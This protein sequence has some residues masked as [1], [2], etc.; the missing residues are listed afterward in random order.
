MNITSRIIAK[1]SIKTGE[2]PG[3]NTGQPNPHYW[4][5]SHNAF[6][7][8]NRSSKKRLPVLF[9]PAR[10]TINPLTPYSGFLFVGKSSGNFYEQTNQKVGKLTSFDV[11][12]QIKADTAKRKISA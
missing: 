8:A 7:S 3:L 10:D 9:S 4:N 1:F 2:R 11:S 6:T 12:A 5:A